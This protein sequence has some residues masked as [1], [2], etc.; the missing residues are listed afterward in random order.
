M[1]YDLSVCLEFKRILVLIS[2]DDHIQV[3]SVRG[4]IT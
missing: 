2:V 3:K 1:I 4:K